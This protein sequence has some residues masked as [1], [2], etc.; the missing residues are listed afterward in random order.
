MISHALGMQLHING[1][2]GVGFPDLS[3]TASDVQLRNRDATVADAKEVHLNVDLRALLRNE[4]QVREIAIKGAT[5]FIERAADGSVNLKPDAPK[6]GA[7]DSA[8]RLAKIS[9]VDS[10]VYYA[11]VKSEIDVEAR[12]CDIDGT[13]LRIAAGKQPMWQ[14]LSL[15][16]KAACEGVRTQ[17]VDLAD[18][19]LAAAVSNGV[20]DIDPVTMKLFEGN[21]SASVHADFSKPVPVFQV[22]YSLERFR[23]EEFLQ[24]MTP[25][26]VAHGDMDF[27]IELSTQ[28]T[29]WDA[30][31]RA[32]SGRSSL[33]G[34]NV[35]FKGVNL[36]VALARFESSQNFNLVD[37]G[38]F[39][40]T[41]PVGLA[42]TKGYNFANL[43]AAGEGVS[44]VRAIVSEWEIEHGKAKAID[45]AMTTNRYR[46]AMKGELDL[47]NERFQDLVVA[48]IDDTGCPKVQQKISGPFNKPVIE[49][50][51]V[52]SAIVGPALN[53]LSGAKN[54]VTGR[55]CSKVFYAGSVPPPGQKN[56]ESGGDASK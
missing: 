25:R 43:L 15:T 27:A 1:R 16:V 33:R 24:A 31:K 12:N 11:D 20:V 53:L 47:V 36:D 34:K 7:R 48:V 38:A 9:I 56:T 52:L 6:S 29:S 8:V 10:T 50:P 44:H 17:N 14:A 21:G 35:T 2:I 26:K 51:N 40:F 32:M 22:R 4:V 19:K 45:V 41:G 55:H 46:I 49:R 23:V 28:G 30:A 54:L 5:L 39:F 37:V 3:L 42:V 13:G 18:V